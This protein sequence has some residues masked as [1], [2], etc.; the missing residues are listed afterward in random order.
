VTLSSQQGLAQAHDALSE[1]ARHLSPAQRKQSEALSKQLDAKAKATRTRL[2][3]ANDP[4][5]SITGNSALQAP[6]QLANRTT[7]PGDALAP[8]RPAADRAAAGHPSSDR[9]V[10]GHPPTA[11]PWRIQLGAFAQA[12]NADALWSRIR[13]RPELA[14]HP[15]IVVAAGNVHRLQASGFASHDAAETACARLDAAGIHCL[16]VLK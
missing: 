7:A 4:G 10:P 14:G 5:D 1:M 6:A 9:S 2:N 13:S 16:P 3:I 15:R 12:G 11:G 8:A